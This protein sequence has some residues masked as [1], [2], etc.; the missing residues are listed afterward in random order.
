[1]SD[2][3]ITKRKQVAPVRDNAIVPPVIT[4][5]EPTDT[6]LAPKLEG[7]VTKRSWFQKFLQ[8]EMP[9]VMRFIMTDVVL[10]A[11]K[12]VISE[13]AS[14][15]VD[16]LLYGEKRTASARVRSTG[17]T[18]YNAIY[19]NRAGSGLRTVAPVRDDPFA[20][21]VFSSKNDAQTVLTSMGDAIAQYGSVSV[22]DVMDLLH[23]TSTFADQR[24]GWTKMEGFRILRLSS[25]G[26]IIEGDSPRSI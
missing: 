14:G 17:R 22:S 9:Q 7:E 26:Y 1:M 20:E 6:K 5:E 11:V 12:D 21:L 4:P 15:A 19:D 23:Q 18:S 2:Q 13:A 8:E 10:P 25:G 24:W 16:M 3:Q